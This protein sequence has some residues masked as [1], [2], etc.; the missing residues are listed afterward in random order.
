LFIPAGVQKNTNSDDRSQ[1]SAVGGSRND[2]G[3]KKGGLCIGT[4]C[5]IIARLGGALI[6]NSREPPGPQTMLRG[7]RRFYDIG[8][9]FMLRG[10]KSMDAVVINKLMGQVQ[11]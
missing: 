8:F 1:T 2:E 7:L 3:A 6:R 5:V 10:E 9:G 11:G 4:A